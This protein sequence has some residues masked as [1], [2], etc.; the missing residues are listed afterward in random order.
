MSGCCVVSMDVSPGRL[1]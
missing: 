1:N